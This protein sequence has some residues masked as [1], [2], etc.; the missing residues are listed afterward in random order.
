MGRLAMAWD[1]NQIYFTIEKVK[2][3]SNLIQNSS[4]QYGGKVEKQSLFYLNS[5]KLFFPREVK[6]KE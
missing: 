4:S 3:G 1:F 2:A 6:Y 5:Y